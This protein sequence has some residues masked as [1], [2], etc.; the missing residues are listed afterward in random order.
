MCAEMCEI[1]ASGGRIRGTK[2][3]RLFSA[4]VRSEITFLN[5][6]R[7]Y[8]WLFGVIIIAAVYLASLRFL[9]L[10]K[11]VV[12]PSFAGPVLLFGSMIAI[13]GVIVFVPIIVDCLGFF[14]FDFKDSLTHQVSSCSLFATLILLPFYEKKN[15]ALFHHYCKLCLRKNYFALGRTASFETLPTPE[16]QVEGVEFEMGRFRLF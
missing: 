1:N 11:L 13:V 14:S 16:R 5:Y 9:G 10:G 7:R 12:F 6:V 2:V 15:R 4:S 3:Q 8:L